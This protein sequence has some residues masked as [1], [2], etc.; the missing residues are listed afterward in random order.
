MSRTILPNMPLPS[1]TKYNWSEC[2]AKLMLERIIAGGLN[3]LTIVDR[4]DLQNRKRNVGIEVTTAVD[5]KVLELERL[6]TELEYGL[7][8]NVDAASKKI[9]KLG[10]KIINGILVHPGRTR[11]LEN[12]Y[13]SFEFKVILLNSKNYTVFKH[14][15]L[16]I[17]DENLIQ[18]SEIIN[19]IIK[20]EL[21]QKKYKYN[22][23]KVYIYFYGD[24]LYEL[25]LKQEKYKIFILSL[26]E[27]H[28]ISIDARTIVEEKKWRC[29]YE[30]G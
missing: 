4:P 3:N 18:E 21:I 12:I 9:Q 8:R 23:E 11:T 24:K 20:F 17:T 27:V 15:Y 5:K 1:N 14:N 30:I 10:G 26:D 16:F 2:F 29:N 7:I 19:M 6:Y 28:K 13:N 25:N 22:F